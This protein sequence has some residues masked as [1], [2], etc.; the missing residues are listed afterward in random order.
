MNK[1]ILSDTKSYS[2]SIHLDPYRSNVH[3]VCL[4]NFN[5][6]ELVD[7][8][9]EKDLQMII[10]FLSNALLELKYANN[11]ASTQTLFKIS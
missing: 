7:G 8:Y 5:T 11:V 3:L 6:V 2:V 1:V 9:D 10:D 4:N